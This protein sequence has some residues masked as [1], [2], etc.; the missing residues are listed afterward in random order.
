M[1]LT[2]DLACNA[3]MCSDWELNQRLFGSQAVTQSTESPSRT[4]TS[5]YS[6]KLWGIIFLV[7]ELLAGWSGLQLGSL[8]PKICLSIFIHHTCMWDYPVHHL[9][10]TPCLSAPLHVSNPPIHPDECGFFKPLVVRLPCS[11][12]F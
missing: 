9:S 5:F 10:V 11:L 3:G 12:I 4:S 8:T 6:Q 2:G 7:L 1:L